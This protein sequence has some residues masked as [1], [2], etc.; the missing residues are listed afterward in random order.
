MTGML[1]LENRVVP[2]LR[3][4]PG[5][6]PTPLEGADMAKLTCSVSG[7]SKPA[8]ARDLCPTH[9]ERWR[10]SAKAVEPGDRP[11]EVEG[12]L[13]LHYAK[14]LCHAHYV[15]H[16]Y[17]IH[18]QSRPAPTRRVAGEPPSP[19]TAD[20]CDVAAHARGLCSKHYA[21]WRR[22]AAAGPDSRGC[23]VKGCD[24]LHY[25][26]SWCRF[27]YKRW[28]N[29]G[30]DPG[31]SPWAE[32]AERFWAKVDRRGPADCWE[33]LG[34]LQPGRRPQFSVW[35]HVEGR[36]MA[37]AHRIAYELELIGD[38]RGRLPASIHLDHLCRNTACCNPGH[39]APIDNATN[40]RRSAH[41]SAAEHASIVSPV[42]WFWLNSPEALP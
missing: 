5:T 22:T 8:K 20:G 1:T 6:W 9:Y 18:R 31:I 3:K 42:A 13:G 23:S 33:W 36:S 25:A 17:E 11:C 34:A 38:Y 21:A 10:A 27:H 30:V 37:T 7:C 39:L 2:A 4:Q 15:E 19:C 16:R 28:E 40:V 26:R 24:R 41:L 29:R 32:L 35:G 12:C 14:G